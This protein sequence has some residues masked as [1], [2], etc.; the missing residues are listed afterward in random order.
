M[1]RGPAAP[2]DAG[3]PGRLR[4]R[5]LLGKSLFSKNIA[6]GV[7]KDGRLCYNKRHGIRDTEFPGEHLHAKQ[8]GESTHLPVNTPAGV[9]ELADARDLKS[10]DTKVSYRFDPGHRHHWLKRDRVA[11]SRGRAVW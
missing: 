4:G 6:K 8:R 10:R 2:A 1:P 5:A 9:A 3:P 7:D 11:I